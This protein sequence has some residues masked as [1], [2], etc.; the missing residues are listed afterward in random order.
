MQHLAPHTTP[1]PFRRHYGLS[2]GTFPKYWTKCVHIRCPCYQKPV[3][4]FFLIKRSF[5]PYPPAFFFSRKSV[6]LSAS[7]TCNTAFLPI[8][9]PDSQALENVQKLALKFLIG[10]SHVCYELAL[11]LMRL[12]SLV[13]RRICGN[14]SCMYKI[15]ARGLVDFQ[16]GADFTVPTRSGLRGHA[17][18]IHQQRCNTRGRQNAFSVSRSP[19]V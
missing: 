1:S 2:S 15:I 8:Y 10:L 4:C 14:L 3:E 17:F 9:L 19:V 6:Y 5:A 13:R 7:W 11:Q 12:F 16:W 18:T